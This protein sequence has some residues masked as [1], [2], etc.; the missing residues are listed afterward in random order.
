MAVHD[1]INLGELKVEFF[2]EVSSFDDESNVF[3]TQNLL[4]GQAWYE[5]SRPVRSDYL[6]K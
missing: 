2:Y 1:W 6:T 5:D 3:V 4:G